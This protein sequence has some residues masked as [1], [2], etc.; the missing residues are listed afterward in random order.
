MIK[1][2]SCVAL[3]DKFLFPFRAIKWTKEELNKCLS[4]IFQNSIVGQFSDLNETIFFR[5]FLTE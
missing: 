5:D 4:V 2:A 3:V 1:K